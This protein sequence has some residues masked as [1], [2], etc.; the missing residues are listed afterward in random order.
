M[1]HQSQFDL[2][3]CLSPPS[4]NI[5]PNELHTLTERIQSIS[6]ILF[7]EHIKPGLAQNA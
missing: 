5:P 3:L 1:F 4:E 7:K 6:H 2:S